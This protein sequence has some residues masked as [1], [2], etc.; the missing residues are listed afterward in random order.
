M[1]AKNIDYKTI[2]I[3]SLKV[4]LGLLVTGI[5]T[6]FMYIVNWGSAPAATIG[7]GVHVFT[8]LSYGVAGI[9]VNVFF[10]IVLF[11]LDKKLINFG[12]ILATFF[13]GVFIDIGVWIITPLH[14]EMMGTAMKAVFLV[15]GCLLTAVGLGYYVGVNFGIGAIDGL[16]VAINKKTNISFSICRWSIDIILMIV[17]IALGA[18]WGVGTIVSIVVTAPI[19]QFIINRTG[20]AAKA[21][22]EEKNEV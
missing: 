7:D 3:K 9:V 8:G 2:L 17:G 1:N 19:M 22:K 20:E 4:I 16:S 13:L 10:L 5:G 18:S 12:T 14:I 21:A 11:F 15:I 6:A